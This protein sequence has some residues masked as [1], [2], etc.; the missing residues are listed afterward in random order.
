MSI[1]RLR[2]MELAGGVI[3]PHAKTAPPR[4]DGEVAAALVPC[5]GHV[6]IR[7]FQHHDR[8]AVLRLLR[9]VPRLYPDGARWLSRRL[10]DVENGDAWC[11]LGI[12]RAR[13][14]AAAIET[15]KPS[16]AI[17]L[18]TF[19]VDPTQQGRGVG[20]LLIADVMEG[21]VR[22]GIRQAYVTVASSREFAIRA[23]LE[24]RGFQ[25]AAQERNRYGRGRDEIIFT[26]SR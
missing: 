21:W 14:I 20:S 5:L 19:Y 18:S 2:T 3:S 10:D 12:D 15:P 25:R 16:G 11:T 9:V 17:K 23:F 1:V 7:P 6:W 26:W 4:A 24:E 8:G 13:P 22:N